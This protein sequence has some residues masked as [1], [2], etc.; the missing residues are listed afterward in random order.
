MFN[1]LKINAYELKKEMKNYAISS[2]WYNVNI[3]QI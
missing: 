1:P 3:K 2:S